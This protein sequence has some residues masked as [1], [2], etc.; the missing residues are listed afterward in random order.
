VSK[1]KEKETLRRTHGLTI[2][3]IT[4]LQM[5]SDESKGKIGNK[6]VLQEKKILIQTMD[7]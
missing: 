7:F 3:Q 5:I 4:I 6:Q 2:N 1:T